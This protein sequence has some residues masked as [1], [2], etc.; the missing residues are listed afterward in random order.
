MPK[1]DGRLPSTPPHPGLSPHWASG[2]GGVVWQLHVAGTPG[3]VGWKKPPQEDGGCL[4]RISFTLWGNRPGPSSSALGPVRWGQKY[5]NR[6]SGFKQKVPPESRLK[7]SRPLVND[8]EAAR[9]IAW[10]RRQ[11]ARGLPGA[12]VLLCKA[13]RASSAWRVLACSPAGVCP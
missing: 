9:R 11:L 7:V 6:K 12:R 8:N 10:C 3:V 4:I 5:S 1:Q 2:S 13:P